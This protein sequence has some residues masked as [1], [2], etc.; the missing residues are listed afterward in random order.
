MC[1]GILK[2]A[3]EETEFEEIHCLI[4]KE[5]KISIHLAQKLGFIWQEEVKIHGK[6]LQRYTKSLQFGEK[7]SIM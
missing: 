2:Y 1:Q 5:N 3:R 4:H 7:L 6:Y